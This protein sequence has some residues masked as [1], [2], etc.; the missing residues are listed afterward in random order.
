MNALTGKVQNYVNAEKSP[1]WIKKQTNV[2]LAAHEMDGAV[3]SIVRCK[4][5]KKSLEVNT[6]I[7]T[8]NAVVTG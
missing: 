3:V 1:K 4:P 2:H 8:P 6:Q 5:L 7:V